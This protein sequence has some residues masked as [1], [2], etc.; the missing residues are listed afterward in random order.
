ME[1]LW[2]YD[3][4][5]NSHKAASHCSIFLCSLTVCRFL[6]S[7]FSSFPSLLPFP[8]LSLPVGSSIAPS[9]HSSLVHSHYFSRRRPRERERETGRKSSGREGGRQKSRGDERKE[10]LK[11]GGRRSLK[12]KS[13]KEGSRVF[14]VAF[15]GPAWRSYWLLHCIPRPPER[16]WLHSSHQWKFRIDKSQ[17]AIC[18]IHIEFVP[19]ELL[20]S[21]STAD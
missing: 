12:L 16:S 5:N 3:A 6:S 14:S 21:R 2:N 7:S 19:C 20:K 17:I 15:K 9:H 1:I 4:T 18:L 8:L 13:D 10:M 11:K